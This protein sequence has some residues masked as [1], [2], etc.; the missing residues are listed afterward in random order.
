MRLGALMRQTLGTDQRPGPLWHVVARG[1]SHRPW[2]IGGSVGV[3]RTGGRRSTAAKRRVTSDEPG[4]GNPGRRR[5]APPQ[6]GVGPVALH[7]RGRAVAQQ[8]CRLCMRHHLPVWPPCMR[9][10]FG[11]ECRAAPAPCPLSSGYVFDICMCFTCTVLRTP[12][13]LTVWRPGRRM[14]PPL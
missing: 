13:V 3:L 5:R 6:V 4:P 2:C 10:R 9:T 7:W 1:G 14:T 8:Q 11:V 12:R